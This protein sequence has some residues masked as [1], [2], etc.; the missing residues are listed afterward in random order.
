[1]SAQEFLVNN[2]DKIIEALITTVQ[3]DHLKHIGEVFETKKARLFFSKDMTKS[4]EDVFQSPVL[5]E[6]FGKKF[7]KWQPVVN[8]EN[9]QYLKNDVIEFFFAPIEN[10][11]AWK[12]F[13][14]KQ[15]VHLTPEEQQI[16]RD[17]IAVA[18]T[19]KLQCAWSDRHEDKLTN[20]LDKFSAFTMWINASVKRQIREKQAEKTEK[21]IAIGLSDFEFAIKNFGKTGPIAVT[22]LSIKDISPNLKKSIQGI[23]DNL[24]F[25]ALDGSEQLLQAALLKLI[26]NIVSASKSATNSLND[27]CIQEVGRVIVKDIDTH[28]HDLIKNRKAPPYLIDSLTKLE[29]LVSAETQKKYRKL[30]DACKPEEKSVEKKENRLKRMSSFFQRNNIKKEDVQK[31]LNENQYQL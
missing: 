11:P 4:I 6:E 14:K 5:L 3:N 17:L 23:R 10:N 1:M 16:V 20:N 12:E 7:E 28:Y 25:H 26:E 19:Y 8:K 22:L 30:F 13:W 29:S 24:H 21:I 31:K 2:S 15:S 27:K 18:V 9:I